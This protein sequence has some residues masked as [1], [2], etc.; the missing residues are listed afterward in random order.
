MNHVNQMNQK[1]LEEPGEALIQMEEGGKM[2]L[3]NLKAAALEGKS[4]VVSISLWGILVKLVIH[5]IRLEK[6]QKLQSLYCGYISDIG[7]H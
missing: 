1:Q 4:C 7:L 3:G 5:Q 6:N 2:V